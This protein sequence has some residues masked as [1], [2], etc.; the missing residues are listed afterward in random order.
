MKPANKYNR[1]VTIER[2]T[3]APD[4]QGG[5]TRSWSVVGQAYVEANPVG[6]TASLIAGTLQQQQPWRIEMPWRADLTQLDRF[7]ATWLP[8]GFAIGIESVNDP[9]GR[10]RSLVAFGTS[11]KV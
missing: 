2:A 6:G 9:D 11:G 8:A 5:Q 3:D 4:G 7:T 1:L 10:S